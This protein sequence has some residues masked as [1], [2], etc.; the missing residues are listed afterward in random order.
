MADSPYA[1]AVTSLLISRRLPAPI[2]AVWRAFTEPKEVAKWFGSDP[3]GV[4][5]H[6]E[7]DVRVGGRFSVTFR[8]S[9]GDEHTASGDYTEVSPPQRLAFSW[10]WRSEPHVTTFVSV[11]L[12]PEGDDT[13]LRCEHAGLGAATTHEYERGWASTFDKLSRVLAAPR[14]G[15]VSR[16]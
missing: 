10:R 14:S 6:A 2:E 16:S 12:T 15:E 8:D 1:R 4:V 11:T 7:L 3:Q 5:L 13:W 9:N